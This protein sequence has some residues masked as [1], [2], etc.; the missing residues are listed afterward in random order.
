MKGKLGDRNRFRTTFIQGKTD[1]LIHQ[2][3]EAGQIV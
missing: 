3:N 2:Q 1:N